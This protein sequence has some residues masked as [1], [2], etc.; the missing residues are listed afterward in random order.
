MFDYGVGRR[1]LARASLLWEGKQ[2]ID[3]TGAG[4]EG[5]ILS[6]MMRLMLDLNGCWARDVIDRE[7]DLGGGR[8]IIGRND[9]LLTDQ[10]RFEER[11][12]LDW[13]LRLRQRQIRWVVGSGRRSI[14]GGEE[15]G[16]VE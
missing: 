11:S 7:E 14:G 1:M 6:F 3:F 8:T 9:L 13:R 10:Q 4:I 15:G 16:V 2:G 5:G 12:P